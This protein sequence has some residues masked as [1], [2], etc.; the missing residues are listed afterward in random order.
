[1]SLRSV[2]TGSLL[3]ATLIVALP[4]AAFAAPED[5]SIELTGSGQG[6]LGDMFGAQILIPGSKISADFNVVRRGGGVSTLSLA[7]FADMDPRGPLG[8]SARVSVRTPTAQENAVLGDLLQEGSVMDLGTGADQVTPVHLEISLPGESGNGTMDRTVPFKIRVT[9]QDRTALPDANAN[10]SHPVAA[11][12]G[13]GWL[14][15]TGASPAPWLWGAGGVI[16]AGALM[17]LARRRGSSP[18]K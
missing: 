1:M 17:L 2:L 5:R 6:E 7:L 13:D 10:G 9:A 3:A 18:Q 12:H 14:S 8:Q 11:G 16:A 15:E 4:G